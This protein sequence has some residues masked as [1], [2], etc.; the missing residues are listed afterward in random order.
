MAGME[1][2]RG[3]GPRR[4][5]GR[6]AGRQGGG[7]REALGAD[8]GPH[9]QEA[10]GVPQER[11]RGNDRVLRGASGGLHALRRAR[12]RHREVAGGDEDRCS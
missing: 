4:S 11:R 7:R 2:Q 8:Q 1:P 3:L 6:R 5:E 9:G 10:E 12:R